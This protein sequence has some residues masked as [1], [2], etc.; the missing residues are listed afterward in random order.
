MKTYI[1]PD[2]LKWARERNKLT[3]E[4]L[5]TKMKRDSGELKMWEDGKQDP[6]LGCLEDLAY[7]HFKIPLA[8]FFFPEP[9]AQADPAN[10]FRRLPDFELERFSDDTYRK[11]RL[12]QAYQD[13]LSIILEDFPSRKIF[14]D[15]I[16]QKQSVAELAS[17]VRSYIGISMDDQYKFSSIE[18]AFKRWRHAIEECGIFTFK[19]SFK[20]R[21]ISGFCLIDDGYPI[22]FI[23]NSNAFS[24]QIFTLVHELAHILFGVD[25]ITDIDETYISSMGKIDKDREIFCNR[26]A[27][28]FLVPDNELDKDIA[29]FKKDGIG[30]VPKIAEKY[31][32]SREVILRR[33]LDKGV[34]TDNFYQ[35]EAQKLNQDYLRGHKEAKG[36]NYYLT[37]LSYLGEG[38]TKAAYE[39]YQAGHLD[40][41]DLANHLNINA[42]NIDKLVSYLRQ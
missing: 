6:P 8:V 2:I 35:K 14:K 29:L 1:N 19:D 42:K 31:S 5:A 16:P 30:S 23:N 26:F 12:A 18:V 24:R 33:L 17:Q 32:V 3:I 25:G 36:G 27:A 37:Q 4:Q 11:I 13:S 21:F 28:Y 15:I 9:P 7:K 20:D 41:I 10:K 34:I 38:Y 22:I 39:Q 40:R